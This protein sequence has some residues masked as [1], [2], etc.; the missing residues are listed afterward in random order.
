M[1][2]PTKLTPE[3][4]ALSKK[5]VPKLVF[6]G[7][8]ADCLGLGRRTIHR[9]M[10]RGGTL[11][12]KDPL[13]EAEALLV[14]FWHTIKKGLAEAE[15]SLIQRIMRAKAWQAQAWLLERRWP[16][17]WGKQAREIRE[18]YKRLKLLEAQLEAQFGPGNGN[19][20]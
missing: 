3:V 4:I 5:L 17:H 6:L 7:T 11:L 18:L 15:I 8:L 1:A 10:A 19:R 13:T 16:E 9:W 14:E 20:P 2:R 12:D